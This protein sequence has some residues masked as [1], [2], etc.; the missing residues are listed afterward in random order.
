MRAITRLPLAVLLVSGGVALLGSAGLGRQTIAP[1]PVSAPA[2]APDR[3]TAPEAEP[4]AA[5]PTR[6]LPDRADQVVDYRITVTLDADKK[7]LKGRQRLTWRNPSTDAVPDLWFH[8]YLNAFKNSKSTFFKESGGQLRGDR[9][10]EDGWGYIDITSMKV[11]G[12]A[13]LTKALTFESPD[14]GNK[15]DQ[16]VA[17]VV[18]PE[19]VPPGGSVTLDVE[20]L[21]KLPRV[22]ARTGFKDDF[23]L[24]G[25]WFPKI[26]VYEPAGRRGRDRGGWNAHQ[27]HANSEFYADYGRFEVSFTVPSRFV[28]GSTGQRTAR[29]DNGD[30]TTTHTYVQADVH[31]FAWTAD[32][33]YLEIRD[34]FSAS[35]DVTA[36]EYARIAKLVDRP[37][38]EVRLSD[39]EVILLLQPRHRPQ[40]QRYISSAKLA[41][42][43]FGLWYGRY[44]YKTL[45]VVDPAPGAGG[46]GGMEYPT[47]ITGGTTVQFN[48]WPFDRIRAPEGVTVHEFGHQ[49]WYGL[50]GSNEFEEAWLDEGFNSYSTAKVMEAGYG[51]EA[52][53]VELLGLEISAVDTVRAQ[54]AAFD[55]HYDR[56]R[57]PAW[58]YQSGTYSFYS[59]TKPEILL[60]TLEN[61]LGEPTMARVMR[62]YHERWRFRHPSSNDFY[63]VANEVSGQDLTWFFQQA[64]EGTETLDY[65]VASVSTRHPRPLTGH[66]EA[67]GKRQFL[68]QKDAKDAS[69]DGDAKEPYESTILVRRHGEFV[70]P[71]EV[72]LKF[73]G[74]PVEVVEWDGVER[75]KKLT[76]TRPEKLE[77]AEV[78][79][80]RKVLL[81]RNWMNNGKRV[82]PDLRVATAWS[83]RWLFWMQQIIASLGW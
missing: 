10:E 72:A 36:E 6:G 73:E 33:N 71:V 41:L 55:A 50:V 66:V 35:G 69:G 54:N 37:E 28:V 78:D 31:D 27:F 75:W 76:Y 56:V 12:G 46:A 38:D 25:Q 65:E 80:D 40:A 77:W 48:R 70:F 74:K 8:L 60:R 22:F 1:R 29:Q 15:D 9:M 32:P 20:F 4:V 13:D 26:A 45:T 19:A 82:E 17:R 18:L 52:S 63:E 14:D 2:A 58:S 67:G 57:Q 81:D 42:K 49:F 47:F 11:S 44:P 7:E 16:S 83:A 79:P 39:V 23:Y 43:W 64:V 68:S 59:Y 34:T 5:L 61:Y 30:G 53:M 51:K 62:T 3:V 24:V 21:S